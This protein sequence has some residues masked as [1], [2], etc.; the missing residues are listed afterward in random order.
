MDSLDFRSIFL[1]HLEGF[2]ALVRIPSVFDGSTSSAEMPCGAGVQQALDCMRQV[3]TQEGFSVHACGHEAIYASCGEGERI[4][5]ASHLDVVAPGEG[6]HR[7]PFSADCDG[8]WVYG[9]GTEDMKSGAWLVFLA[10]KTARDQGIPLHRTFRLVYGSDEERTMND[11]RHYVQQEGLPA[12]AFTPDGSFPVT[13]GEKGALMWTI[14]G[15]YQGLVES[16]DCGVQCNVIPPSASACVHADN[17]AEAEA[18]MR[19]HGIQGTARMEAGL[20]LLSVTGRAAHVSRPELGHSATADLLAVL[21]ALYHDPLME[22]L[23]ASFADPYGS[24][25]GIACDIAPMGRLTMSLGVLKLKDGRISGQADCRYP[26]GADAAALTE[27]LRRALPSLQ[28]ELPY[29]DPPTLVPPEDPYIRCL[30]QAYREAAGREDGFQVSGGVSYSKVYGHCVNFGPQPAGT[31]SLAH[32]RDERVSIDG[33]VQALEIYY[34]A[35][36]RLGRGE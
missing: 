7:D 18:F 33:C 14:E 30:Q 1:S 13:I 8:Q 17:A 24:G 15:A 19:A 20:L 2:R 12:F 11:L 16:L 35:I 29:N 3:L 28:V 22:Q 27:S 23:R 25:A 31:V 10:L 21:A 5:I 26:H 4:D 6:W 36:C 34:R 32:Q 9:R